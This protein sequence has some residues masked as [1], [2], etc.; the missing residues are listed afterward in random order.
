MAFVSFVTLDVQ[1]SK[2]PR[3]HVWMS[4]RWYNVGTTLNPVEAV[5]DQ[6][7]LDIVVRAVVYVSA[8]NI[9]LFSEPPAKNSTFLCGS[10]GSSSDGTLSRMFL[11]RHLLHRTFDRLDNIPHVI[12]T[13]TRAGRQTKAKLEQCFRHTIDI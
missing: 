5:L 8:A 6:R 10:G 3:H 2:A 1:K 9:Q 12:V 11:L 7:A 4:R 13:D